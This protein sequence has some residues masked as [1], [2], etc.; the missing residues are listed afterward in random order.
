M[1]RSEF[2]ADRRVK[3]DTPQWPI[4]VLPQPTPTTPDER[5]RNTPLDNPRSIDR[6]ARLAPATRKRR[7]APDLTSIWRGGRK[8]NPSRGTHSDRALFRRGDCSDVR[9]GRSAW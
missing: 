1:M 3:S 7:S 2:S 8:F 9:A 4:Y 6:G 5:N